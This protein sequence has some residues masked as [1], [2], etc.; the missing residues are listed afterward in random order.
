MAIFLQFDD[1]DNATIKLEERFDFSDVHDFRRCYENIDV[2]KACIVTIDFELTS[3]I[4]SSA[5]GMLINLKR[6]F[7]GTDTKIILS[8]CNAR[9]MKIFSISNFEKL[10][11]FS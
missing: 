11:N 8:N 6:F 1:S 7:E 10:F 5:L 3:Q 9:I 2:E 4:D